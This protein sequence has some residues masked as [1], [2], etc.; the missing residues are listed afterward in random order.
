MVTRTRFQSIADATK[1][2][3][4][5]THDNGSD[6]DSESASFYAANLMR[7]FAGDFS[8]DA[9]IFEEDDADE[10]VHEQD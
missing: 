6:E 5:E 10:D 8:T 3:A 9:H 2:L 7:N 4:D 1:A